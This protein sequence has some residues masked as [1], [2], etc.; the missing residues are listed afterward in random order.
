MMNKTDVL[1]GRIIQRVIDAK[2]NKVMMPS[3]RTKISIT[4]GVDNTHD[5]TQLIENLFEFFPGSMITLKKLKF[6]YALNIEV[7]LP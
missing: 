2:N 7:A 1:T 6:G 4:H 5:I 3:V